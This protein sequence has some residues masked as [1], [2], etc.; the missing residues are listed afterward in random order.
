MIWYCIACSRYE[1][2]E[3][4]FQYSADLD[5]LV[6][7]SGRKCTEPE[8]FLQ[9]LGCSDE[10]V[11]SLVAAEEKVEPCDIDCQLV[12]EYRQSIG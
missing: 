1:I 12:A 2:W 4:H 10:R 7:W 8:V 9:W 5:S 3:E 6:P 11:R